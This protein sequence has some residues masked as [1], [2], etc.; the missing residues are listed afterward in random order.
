MDDG[1]TF[2]HLSKGKL[3]VCRTM[4]SELI[5]L[6]KLTDDLKF[7]KDAPFD[8]EISKPLMEAIDILLS[9]TL[10]LVQTLNDK[11]KF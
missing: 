9:K 1:N 4:M 5:E 11:I 8:L 3:A 2:T 10:V 7:C 6:S